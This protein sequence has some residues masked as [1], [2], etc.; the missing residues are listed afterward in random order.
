MGVSA[1]G[2]LQQCMLGYTPTVNRIT[3]ACENI[4]FLQLLLRTVK[5][6]FFPQVMDTIL[7]C[8]IY[9]ETV[10]MKTRVVSLHIHHV[11]HWNMC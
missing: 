7:L 10:V 11:E 1:K 2:G 5:I 8:I 4:T 3:D 6:K 9:D